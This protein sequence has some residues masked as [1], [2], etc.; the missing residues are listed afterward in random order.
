MPSNL[1]K[2]TLFS[3]KHSTLLFERYDDFSSLERLVPNW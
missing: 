3:S 2:K 1:K